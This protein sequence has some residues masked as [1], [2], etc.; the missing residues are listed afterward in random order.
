MQQYKQYLGYKII[1]NP[2][3]LEFYPSGSEPFGLVNTVALIW[4]YFT[5]TFYLPDVKK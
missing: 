1:L 2:L 4:P 3:I 5:A